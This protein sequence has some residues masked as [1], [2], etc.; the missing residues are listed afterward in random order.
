MMIRDCSRLSLNYSA[1]G[2]SCTQ[3]IVKYRDCESSWDNDITETMYSS[4][5]NSVCG[6]APRRPSCFKSGAPR[7]HVAPGTH[8]VSRL[9]S[10]SGL[11]PLLHAFLQQLKPM[12]KL[13]RCRNSCG[14]LMLVTT[15]IPDNFQGTTET[16]FSVTQAHTR[17]V[18][19]A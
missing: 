13:E 8:S 9:L 6:E 15:G 7:P 16:L 1:T 3:T 12:H 17:E 14:P 4:I 11:E 19:Q 18:S 2:C 10:L 5:R